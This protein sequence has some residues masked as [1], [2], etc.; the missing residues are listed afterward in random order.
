MSFAEGGKRL[1]ASLMLSSAVFQILSGSVW[2]IFTLANMRQASSRD[3]EL[4]SSM[5]SVP[6]WVVELSRE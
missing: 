5:P 2:M 3:L 4:I 6:W 1:K